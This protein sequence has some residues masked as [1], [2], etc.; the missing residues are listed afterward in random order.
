M[1]YWQ[2]D[3]LLSDDARL[4][5]ITGLPV[6]R[7]RRSREPVQAKFADGWKHKR[8][9]A[10][11]AKVDRAFMQ[12]RLAGRN[13]GIKSGIAR[14]VAQG[15]AII[16]AEAEGRRALA[17]NRSERE[18]G[19]QAELNPPRTNH[20]HRFSSSSSVERGSDPSA[21]AARNVMT[22]PSRPCSRPGS[23]PPARSRV[24]VHCE[25][26][27]RGALADLKR[28]LD[29]LANHFGGAARGRRSE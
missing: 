2:H 12:R 19:G 11:I 29:A 21:G 7:W 18:A 14:A 8:I 16:R 26:C 27:P 13:G 25:P 17:R 15:E 3:G 6:A 4:A 1:H 23:A 22:S 5:A 28:D 9:E 10:E 20:N 24:A